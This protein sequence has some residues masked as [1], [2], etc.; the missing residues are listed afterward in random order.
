MQYVQRH[1]EDP[2]VQRQAPPCQV[3]QAPC[4]FTTTQLRTGNK[5]QHSTTVKLSV[6][7]VLSLPLY[8]RVLGRIINP[9]QVWSRQ[10]LQVQAQRQGRVAVQ[11]ALVELIEHN[12]VCCRHLLVMSRQEVV[13]GDAV[14][15][16]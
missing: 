2:G 5:T 4:Q 12:L 3:L 6:L 10:A 13:K 11:V 14:K 16:A 7:L 8:A 9:P 15:L 1:G